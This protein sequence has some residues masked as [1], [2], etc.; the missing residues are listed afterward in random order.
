MTLMVELG[1]PR[2]S[3]SLVSES[4]FR[5]TFIGLT[6]SLKQALKAALVG[7]KDKNMQNS[8]SLSIGD[9]L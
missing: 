4:G 5:S 6:A 2:R 3:L 9:P 1:A 7:D 8:S